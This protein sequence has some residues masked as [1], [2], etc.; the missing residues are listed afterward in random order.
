MLKRIGVSFKEPSTWTGIIGLATAFGAHISPEHTDAIVTVG[1]A[2]ASLLG[3]AF[4]WE[5]P[6][7]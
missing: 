6:S 7:T 2:L 1:T 4:K 3:I 5:K